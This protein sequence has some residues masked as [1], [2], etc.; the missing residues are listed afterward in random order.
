M[1]TS[2][3]NVPKEIIHD[4]TILWDIRGKILHEAD[5]D[6]PDFKDLR[7]IVLTWNEASHLV[8]EG[9]NEMCMYLTGWTFPRLVAKA[10]TAGKP[11]ARGSDPSE[12]LLEEWAKLP[13]G[14]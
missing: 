12:D 9:I 8:R 10:M 6:Q 1:D 3:V 2:Y 5:I 13:K 11:V 4:E 7:R 14:G